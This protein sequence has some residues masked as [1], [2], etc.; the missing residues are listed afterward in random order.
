MSI[1]LKFERS[2]I[3]HSGLKK[4]SLTYM[5]SI[6]CCHEEHVER[7]GQWALNFLEYISDG[8]KVFHRQCPFSANVYSMLDEVEPMT[9][10][11][12]NFAEGKVRLI[13]LI[14]PPKS[15]MSILKPP[16]KDVQALKI[17]SKNVSFDAIA[18]PIP[19][20]SH[21]LVISIKRKSHDTST[22]RS[23]DDCLR[24]IVNL[25]SLRNPPSNSRKTNDSSLVKVIPRFQVD[26]STFI[27]NN[28][29]I[30]NTSREFSKEKLRDFIVEQLRQDTKSKEIA[31]EY[32]KPACVLADNRSN[33]RDSQIKLPT[34]FL[35]KLNKIRLNK[36]KPQSINLPH[37][38]EHAASRLPKK[39]DARHPDP[40]FFLA[41][42]KRLSTT[43]D[44]SFKNNTRL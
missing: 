26:K 29:T 24:E 1:R 16:S 37:I 13:S 9:V 4:R 7:A 44:R 25:R 40:S 28:T 43:Q 38:D 12:D 35:E 23:M 39:T 20:K 34:S 42:P 2:K 11:Q 21:H 19:K 41:K 22:R 5:R 33:I 10:P 6:V 32:T 30:T 8:N 15:R 27:I 14:R 31:S 18:S 3:F 17:P 36:L